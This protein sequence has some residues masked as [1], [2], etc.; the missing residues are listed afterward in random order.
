MIRG[1]ARTLTLTTNLSSY[2]LRH[3]FSSSTF[4][5]KN[6]T[7]D[8]FD[9][10]FENLKNHI[11]QADFV[12]VDLE[13]T[14]VT[15]APWR[16]SFDFDRNDIR[17]LKIKD[18]VE[19]FAV[20]QFGVCPFRWDDSKKTFVA[21]PH[22]FYIFPR[23]ELPFYDGPAEEFLCQATSIDFLAKYKFDFNAC[24]HQ[25]ISYL[26]REQ[27]AEARGRLKLVYDE[28]NL[29][30]N[31][32]EFSDSTLISNADILFTCRLKKYLEEWR[33]RLL[34]NTNGG[35]QIDENLK[36]LMPM[37][38]T[39]FYKMRPALRLK[40]FTSHQLRLIQLITTKHFQDLAFVH[41]NGESS[42][43]ENLLVYTDSEDGGDV[44]M[45]EVSDDLHKE[46]EMK[47][48]AATG[49]RRVIDLLS[50][51]QKLLVGHN[52][53]LDMAHIYSKFIGPLP[54]TI[55]EYISSVHK[56]FPY[57]IDTKLLLNTDSVIQRLMKKQSTSLS[58][59]FALLCPQIAVSSEASVKGLKI[60]VRVDDM[61]SS[62]WNSGANHEAGYD[63]FMTGCIFAQACSHLG[64]GFD[65]NS[66][67][68][69]LAEHE[70][71]QKYINLLY[72]SWNN[73]AMID[74]RTGNESFELLTQQNPKQRYSRI[75][76]ENVVLIWGFPS[77]LKTREIKDCVTKVFGSD[78]VTSVYYLDGTAAFIQFS[79]KEL[80]SD[81]LDRKEAIT[82]SDPTL[83]LHPLPKLL[84]GG[85]THA[86]KYDVYKEICSSSLS[87]KLFSDQAEALGIK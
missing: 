64:I 21:H 57:I 10:V 22:N 32:E 28:S 24:I 82:E 6:V 3:P 40:G 65:N 23:K 47:L 58:S 54:P 61:R 63:A 55:D 43:K 5:I 60:E 34:M 80:V 84:G 69:G 16:D 56:V 49:F 13:M 50:S 33:D 18:S 25:G 29:A 66:L 17:Y 87:E 48:K 15:S 68:K 11:K 39:V 44:V 31:L 71:L 52:S 72:L 2:N 41:A 79:K 20:V 45:K 74:L 78:S 70:N 67:A 7:R 59:A 4:A 26:S 77:K 19:K 35:V 76:F 30:S 73:G 37:F 8:N 42:S 1:F 62:N 83:V 75:L 85:K 36:D 9:S 51:E 86:A 12:S 53:F 81:F 46:A 27:E 14:G 38:E